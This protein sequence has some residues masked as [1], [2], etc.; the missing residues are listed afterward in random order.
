MNADADQ[1]IDEFLTQVD[2]LC[3]MLDDLSLRGVK[4]VR[5]YSTTPAQ[6]RVAERLANREEFERREFRMKMRKTLVGV[7]YVRA[8]HRNPF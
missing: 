4:Q 1:D 2:E 5:E 7:K 3:D 6:R 8:M